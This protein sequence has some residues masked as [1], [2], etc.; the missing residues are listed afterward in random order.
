MPTATV[1][2]DGPPK[3][4]HERPLR[5]AVEALLLLKANEE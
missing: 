1:L 2:K 4:V 5:E 3:V